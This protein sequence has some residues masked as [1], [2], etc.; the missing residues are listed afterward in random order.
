MPGLGL[1]S[2]NICLLTFL[3]KREKKKKTEGGAG[4][5]ICKATGD[6]LSALW[7]SSALISA[8]CSATS[9]VEEARPQQTAGVGSQ[10]ALLAGLLMPK[11][12]SGHTPQESHSQRCGVFQ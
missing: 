8:A 5:F 3:S 1:P 7:S 2:R 12:K 11:D 9:S 4:Q 10:P 6:G